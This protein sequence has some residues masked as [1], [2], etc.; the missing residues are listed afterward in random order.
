MS[1]VSKAQLFVVIFVM[2]IVDQAGF[3]KMIIFK[4]MEAFCANFWHTSFL[5]FLRSAES[6]SAVCQAEKWLLK[7]QNGEIQDGRHSRGKMC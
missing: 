1:L 3:K 4:V 2:I 5:G 7:P 6:E